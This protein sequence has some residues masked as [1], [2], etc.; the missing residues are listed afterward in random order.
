[1]RIPSPDASA[2]IVDRAPAQ[3]TQMRCQRVRRQTPQATHRHGRRTLALRR[4]GSLSVIALLTTA[5]AAGEAPGLSPE[6]TI[7]LQTVEE[8]TLSPDGEH[9]VYRADDWVDADGAPRRRRGRLW[10]LPVKGGEPEPLDSHSFDARSPQWSPDGKRIAWIAKR[11]SESPPQLFVVQPDGGEAEQL[12]DAPTGVLMFRWSPDAMDI[13]YTSTGPASDAQRR[14]ALAGKD[15]RIA[16]RSEKQRRLHVVNIRTGRSAPV[17]TRLVTVHDF[18]WSPN[19]ESF[20]IAAAPGPGDDDRA[21]RTRPFLVPANGGEPTLLAATEGKLTHPA[22]SVDGH[23]IAWLG[24]TSITDPVAGSVFAVRADAPGEARNLTGSF[25]GTAVWLAPLPGKAAAFAFVAEEGQAT[26][27]RAA[28]AYSGAITTISAPTEIFSGGASFSVDGGR[29]AIVANSPEHPDELF[30]NAADGAADIRRLTR[31]NPELEGIS[32]GAQ[33][34]LRWRSKDGT[35]IEGVLV[36]PPGFRGDMQYP[37]VLHIHGGS[38]SVVSNG[39]QAGFR[40]FGQVLAGRGFIVLYPNYRGSRGRGVEFVRGNR[41]DMMGRSWEDIESGLDALLEAGIADRERVGIYGFSWGGYAAGWGATY[42]SRRFRAAVAGAGIYNWISEAG[43]NSTRMHEQLAHWDAPLY[44]NFGLYLER[45]PIFW[46]HRAS[47][48]ILLLH[49]EEDGSCPVGQAIEFRTALEWK[50]VP[51]ELVIY[52]REGHG[53]VEFEHQL[54]F[55]SRG[56]GWFDRFLQ[57]TKAE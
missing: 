14:D 21:L 3:Q 44:E 42:A 4:Q 6:L 23:W 41:R 10:H 40:N 29:F 16:G 47:T 15:W 48:P 35:E 28:D 27:L 39:W 53:M 50:G 33:E 5:A 52:P 18:A 26:V 1:M 55:L 56:V 2:G 12:T 34:I 46:V 9:V 43:S 24:S 17:T 36:K 7:A 22:W 25:A 38:E 30:V 31:T 57:A 32:L 49:G 20:V 45:S 13:G 19:G 8:V 37:V 51:N 11:R 54:D